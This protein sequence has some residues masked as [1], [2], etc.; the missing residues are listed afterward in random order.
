MCDLHRLTASR[1][2]IVSASGI[3]QSGAMAARP[4]KLF[5]KSATFSLGF[6]YE[7]L[8]YEGVDVEVGAEEKQM[9]G[10]DEVLIESRLLVPSRLH[11]GRAFTYVQ[12]HYTRDEF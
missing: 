12:S 1:M 3:V 10:L 9:E 7:L 4:S 2:M 5:S 11:H 8:D 6:S